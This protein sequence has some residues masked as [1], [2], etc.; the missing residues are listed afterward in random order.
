MAE[1]P[2]ESESHILK[3]P[4]DLKKT[5]KPFPKFSQHNEILSSVDREYRKHAGEV[6]RRNDGTVRA[7]PPPPRP[8]QAKTI[9]QAKP[10]QSRKKLANGFD[11]DEDSDSDRDRSQP[12]FGGRDGG[13]TVRKKNRFPLTSDGDLQARP[14]YSEAGPSTSMQLTP[15]EEERMKLRRH[16]NHHGLGVGADF[17]TLR[18]NEKIAK[19]D[20]QLLL[21]MLQTHPQ[22]RQLLLDNPETTPFKRQWLNTDVFRFQQLQMS[23][24]L[25]EALCNDIDDRDAMEDNDCLSEGI[26]KPQLLEYIIEEAE[27]KFVLWWEQFVT[28]GERAVQAVVESLWTQ[29]TWMDK[30][31]AQPQDRNGGGLGLGEFAASYE[32]WIVTR[33]GFSFIYDVR[34]R[35]P[36]IQRSVYEWRKSDLG[37][38]KYLDT[39]KILSESRKDQHMS[40]EYIDWVCSGTSPDMID[41]YCQQ[42]LR[43]IRGAKIREILGS[44]L[45]GQAFRESTYD[46]GSLSLVLFKHGHPSSIKPVSTLDREEMGWYR[47][48]YRRG[49]SKFYRYEIDDELGNVFKVGMD[50]KLLSLWTPRGE[51]GWVDS[52]A[53]PKITMSS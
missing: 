14:K 27:T 2:T 49:E 11:D 37:M 50:G 29:D 42:R 35:W 15:E 33:L 26:S 21:H 5:S 48:R 40:H 38:S 10:N 16:I 8:A 1:L 22:G 7:E 17:W 32:L 53:E 3:D 12:G 4:A 6:R 30:C 43:Q 23:H 36:V 25:D 45:T 13:A 9:N 24:F 47:G 46:E 31:K 18:R 41:R 20:K 51:A 52:Q 44:R 19:K 28:P 34:S 39:M